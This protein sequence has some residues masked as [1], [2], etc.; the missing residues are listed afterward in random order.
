MADFVGRIAGD[1]TASDDHRS[2]VLNSP[3]TIGGTRVVGRVGRVA[4]D[5]RIGDRGGAVVVSDTATAHVGGVVLDNAV[6]NA[7]GSVQV[8]N[9]SPILGSVPAGDGHADEFQTGVVAHRE[10][11]SGVTQAESPKGGCV[12]YRGVASCAEDGG[13]ARLP[14]DLERPEM[15]RSEVCVEG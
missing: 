7:Q 11:P 4:A 10:D 12:D 8:P 15:I 9:P 6:S 1:F 2:C 14:L 3:S 5:D 13:R